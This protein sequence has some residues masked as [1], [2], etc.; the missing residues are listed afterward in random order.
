[1]KKGPQKGQMLEVVKRKNSL[2]DIAKVSLRY[3]LVIFTLMSAGCW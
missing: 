1:V 2:A 3:S